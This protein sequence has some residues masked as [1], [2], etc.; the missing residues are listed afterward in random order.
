M[1]TGAEDCVLRS[2]TYE[3]IPVCKTFLICTFRLRRNTILSQPAADSSFPKEPLEN[4]SNKEEHS[5]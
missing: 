1:H 4:T 5:K 3:V 2:K